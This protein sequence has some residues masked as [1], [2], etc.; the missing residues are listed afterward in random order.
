M[1]YVKVSNFY[2]LAP[3][4]IVIISMKKTELH[5]IWFECLHSK[6]NF[7]DINNSKSDDLNEWVKINRSI[8]V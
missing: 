5:P 6:T 8:N 1:N 7:S 4:K 2:C 3:G